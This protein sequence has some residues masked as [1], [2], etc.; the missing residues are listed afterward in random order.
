MTFFDNRKISLQKQPLMH[1]QPSKAWI[2]VLAVLV[3]IN[4]RPIMA[5]TG[6][7]LDLLQQDLK[8]S[9][10]Q[11]GLMT[12]L[13]VLMMGLF[14]LGGPWLQRLVGEV[15]GVAMGMT[16]IAVACASRM[17]VESASALIATAAL[18]GIGIAII[19]ALMPVFL[20]RNY[21]DSAGMLM[22]LFTTG[23][24]GGAALAAAAA[25]P[26]ADSL[27]WKLTLGYA[28]IPALIA[29]TVWLFTAGSSQ[30]YPAAARLPYRSARAWLLLVFFGIGT[31]AYTLVLAW[32][33][34]YYVEL[35]WT[36]ADA[37]YL[38]AALTVTEVFAGLLVSSLI[39]HSADR[40]TPVALV[41]VLLI[42]GLICMMAAP[43]ELAILATV[44]LGL[45]IG[46]LFPLSLIITLDHANSP[47]EAGSLLAFVQGG[48]YLIAAS[49]P[50]FAGIVRDHLASLHW[51]W[52]MMIIGAMV[53]LVLNSQL[54][55][56]SHRRS[57]E[58][59][60]AENLSG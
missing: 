52:G 26:S 3:G 39:H 56:Y 1:S 40:R 27:G 21:P 2:T 33:A 23:I 54:R 44:C 35:G 51:A 31:A 14:A 30:S 12:T 5:S 10:A 22:G 42:I 48:G 24:M 13:P 34:P 50:V 9:N 17:Y 32:L 46:A 19:Q 41:I 36:A 58:G 53:L 49:M 18:G 55:P 43:H 7:L 4:L 16:L 6:P 11:G 59:G 25:A 20:K 29:L 47:G 45:G 37:G 57:I 60:E 15:R 8:L 38:L 28:A